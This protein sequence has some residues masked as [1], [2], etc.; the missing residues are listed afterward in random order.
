[1]AGES[2]RR[3]EESLK[4]THQGQPCARAFEKAGGRSSENVARESCR[5]GQ[6]PPYPAG[7][8]GTSD[9]DYVS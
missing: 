1:M 7:D 8:V 6:S 9:P 3:K 2:K 5:Y 4:G